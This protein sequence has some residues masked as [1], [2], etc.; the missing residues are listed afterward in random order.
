MC[1]L[2]Y[3][4]MHDI[5]W[6]LGNMLWNC[7]TNKRRREKSSHYVIITCLLMSRKS[8]SPRVAA[9]T[10]HTRWLITSR[11]K[12]SVRHTF[13]HYYHVGIFKG[14]VHPEMKFYLFLL[15]AMS[16]VVSLVTFSNGNNSVNTMFLTKICV[17]VQIPLWDTSSARRQHSCLHWNLSHESFWTECSSCQWVHSGYFG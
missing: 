15:P 14:V 7:F 11:C 9:S 16:P 4:G 2:R 1:T 8:S 12:T 10:E 3:W 5:E 6:F 17:H 13:L